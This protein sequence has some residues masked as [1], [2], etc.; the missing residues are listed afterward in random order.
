LIRSLWFPVPTSDS[1]RTLSAG[2]AF[3][4]RRLLSTGAGA[5][6][7]TTLAGRLLTGSAR[8]GTARLSPAAV[9][10]A[11]PSAAEALR[12]LGRSTFR[13]PDSLPEPALP[14]GTDTMPAIE[15]VV[16]LMLENH[17]Y[18]NLFGMLGRA[19]GQTPRGDGFAL[20]ADGRPTA[21]NPYPDGKSLRAFHMPTTCQ[22]SSKPSQEWEQSHIQYADGKLN[23]FVV[24][25]SGPV[26]MG[27]WTGQD[28]PFTYDLATR[29]P[30][31]D[32]WFCS[33]LAQTDPNRRFLIAATAMGMTDDI[34]TSPGGIVP[35]GSLGVPAPN[36]T[37]FDRLTQ[38]GISWTDYA[39]SF[40][41]GTTM[42][43]YPANDGA[44][45][46]TNVKSIDQFFT[47][48]AAGTLPSFSLLDPNYSTQSQENPQNIVVGE[49]FLAKAVRAIGSSPLWRR[50]LFI[51][52]YDEHGGYYDH[53]PP[54]AAIAPDSV[55]PQVQPGES[56]Y[57]GYARYGFRVPAVIVGP[58]AKPGYVSH[59]VYDHTSIL[60]FLERK[61]NL[62][63][64]TYRDANANS[65][66]DFLDLPA[67]AAGRPTFPELPS[68][69][70]SGENT[71]T[72]ACNT[73]GP[74]KIPPT[75]PDAT[76][77]GSPPKLPPIRVE[78]RD[79]SVRRRL[80]GLLL[81]FRTSHGTLR[82]LT[83]ELHQGRRRVARHSLQRLAHAERRILFRVGGHAPRRGR[84]T[85]VVR[86]GHRT[87]L[88]REI[89]VR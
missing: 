82:G 64:L 43:L 76:A 7:G 4:R 16:V 40:P 74:G 32:R 35:D 8:A 59:V 55:G 88:R 15:H 85:V 86:H 33:T 27:Y 68:L 83:I 71:R 58:Y 78:L 30:I 21:S 39:E 67:M 62:P 70:A 28:L 14:T 9:P 81:Q 20:G 60:A 73:S 79:L 44:F 24:S 66:N 50:T 52:T 19:K 51:L 3:T 11:R 61:W 72:L 87:L 65:L 5:V 26:A 29:F 56:T 48:A 84:Y 18:D 36:G 34:G 54:P 13:H 46:K 45:S 23:G 12:V 25:D 75:G 69:A 63:A 37:I 22:L 38:A 17:S 1:A 49:D 31:G 42:E 89:R 53:V 10:Y 47:D 6:A 41:T 57:D 2:P 80:H 77:G